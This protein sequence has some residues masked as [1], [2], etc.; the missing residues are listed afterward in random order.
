MARAIILEESIKMQAFDKYANPDKWAKKSI[1]TPLKAHKYGAKRTMC[2][3][4]HNH[5]SQKEAIWCVKLHQMQSEGKIKNL[6]REPIYDLRVNNIIVCTHC[7][8]FEYEVLVEAS[9]R[10]EVLDVKG[11]QLPLWKL[12]YKLFMACYPQITYK[13]V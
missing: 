12:K 11:L 1:T 7:P 6:F 5:D 8:D 2:L 9:W 13:V 10:V 4:K 3:Y